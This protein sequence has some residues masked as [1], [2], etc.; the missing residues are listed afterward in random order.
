MTGDIAACLRDAVKKNGRATLAVSGGRTPQHIFPL[1]SGAELPWNRVAITLVD[2]R[3]VD[4]EHPDSNEGLARRLLIQ[5]PA[6]VARFTGLKT[7][8][9]DPRDGC[10][11]TENRL[12][13]IKW[14]LDAVFLGMGVDGHI[15]SLFPDGD[16]ADSDGRAVGIS[17]SGDRQARISLTP[18]A[19]L[20]SRH[21]FLVLS[22]PDKKAA[23]DRALRPGP[24]S[25]LP[26]R[27]VLH[28]A[29]VP[30]TVY[31]SP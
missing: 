6:A 2:E 15:A 1:L 16:W 12:A 22:G 23:Y 20:D 4:A 11:E 17:A 7:D 10:E 27:L 14:P 19:L 9:A 5:G 28:Q 26:V 25:E 31:I 18:R 3:W 30:V 24:V 21:L 13:R 29:A 8:A